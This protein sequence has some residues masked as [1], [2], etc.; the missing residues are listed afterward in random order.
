[1][2]SRE[3]AH[4]GPRA[5][6]SATLL[7]VRSELGLRGE[8]VAEA[9][10]RAEQRVD[11]EQRVLAQLRRRKR[12]L[13]V[14]RVRAVGDLQHDLRIA[15]A[16][17]P[18]R[19]LDEDTHEGV[20][21]QTRPVQARVLVYASRRVARR[22]RVGTPRVL[23]QVGHR[24]AP[25]VE[26]EPRSWRRRSGSAGERRSTS[27]CGNR[28]TPARGEEA[29]VMGSQNGVTE[30]RSNALRARLEHADLPALAGRSTGN[31]DCSGPQPGIEQH[32]GRGDEDRKWRPGAYRAEVLGLPPLQG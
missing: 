24:V 21:V 15:I 3:P 19:L 7:P 28:P 8:T 12:E 32:R 2:N 18:G 14:D 5:G 4:S 26:N 16:T 30:L 1:M 27:P 10:E 13:E 20:A 23:Q 25:Q 6:L 9:V 11:L 22:D 29:A 31:R 17:M